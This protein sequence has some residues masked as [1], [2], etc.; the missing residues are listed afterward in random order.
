MQR[1]GRA[2]A[3]PSGVQVASVFGPA[4]GQLKSGA[5]IVAEARATGRRVHDQ[6]VAEAK[7]LRYV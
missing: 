3:K 5:G 1:V 4:S 2:L 6:Q 7:L